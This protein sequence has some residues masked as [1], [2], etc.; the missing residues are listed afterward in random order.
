M[1]KYDISSFKRLFLKKNTL[2][3]LE[4]ANKQKK[5]LILPLEFNKVKIQYFQNEPIPLF[6]MSIRSAHHFFVCLIALSLLA[7]SSDDMTLSVGEGVMN[8]DHLAFYNDDFIIE[9][10]TKLAEYVTTNNTGVALC[11]SYS[12]DYIGDITTNTVFKI[13]PN[14]AEKSLSSIKTAVYDSIVFV[15]YPN[16][17]IYG[18]SSK[19]VNLTLHKLTEDYILDTLR[20]AGTTEKYYHMSN[21][22]TTAFDPTVLANISFVPE[23][24]DSV[25]IRLS[26][27]IGQ[28]W[29]DNIFNDHDDYTISTDETDDEDFISE[30]LNGLTIRSVAG[31]SAV[32]GFNMPT[33]SNLDTEPGLNIRL[34]YHKSGPY[35]E[36]SHD[37]TIY[38]PSKQYN[39]ITADFSTGLLDGIVAG[40]EGIPSSKTDG[41]TF[42]QSGLGLMTNIEIPTLNELENLGQNLTIIDLD[43]DFSAKSRSFMNNHDLP[44]AMTMLQ[45]KKNGELNSD[46]LLNFSGQ[47]VSISTTQLSTTDAS[48]S[49]PITR[50]GWAEQSLIG[51]ESVDHNSLLLTARYNGAFLPNVNRMVI[52]N[53]DNSDY[54][55]KVK[56]YYTIFE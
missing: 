12:D 47:Q 3:S 41:L 23:D 13:S 25:R 11:G 33:S 20:I 44:L 18:D 9:S 50:Y 7:C 40:G 27:V 19:T 29:F 51:P 4:R 52:G 49:L 28:E 53:S 37:F 31:N 48:F 42:I 32:V 34:Y 36:L 46:G 1:C 24:D 38:D 45:L 15:M 56:M 14:I 39:Q 22:S 43:L 16:N 10:E 55:M 6:I 30:V 35:Q 2:F 54:Q 8:D 5:N 17:Y 26:D 21:H